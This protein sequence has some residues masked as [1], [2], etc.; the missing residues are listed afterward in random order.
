M[1]KLL[2][3]ALAFLTL[4]SASLVAQTNPA[5][6][7]TLSAAL[8]SSSTV[9]RVTSASGLTAG[10]SGIYVDGEYMNVNAIS[11]TV[12]TVT[13]GQL[14]TV[15]RAHVN[16]STVI[17][18]PA[19]MFSTADAGPGTCPSSPQ[20]YLISVNVVNGN[21]WLCRYI[22]GGGRTWQATNTRLLTYNS[23]TIGD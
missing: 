6:S 18:G 23:L 16:A 13:R 12:L 10:A 17:K 11:G 21:V 3:V 22:T 2:I 20:T 7:T 4:A 15:A 9:V 8:D 19:A 14:G 5:T 1:K